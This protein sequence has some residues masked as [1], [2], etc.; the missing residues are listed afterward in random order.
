MIL[1]LL[2]CNGILSSSDIFYLHCYFFSI[3]IIARTLYNSL[4]FY[5]VMQKSVMSIPCPGNVQ[6]LLK[7]QLHC[8]YGIQRCR[9]TF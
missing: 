9:D 7:K 3:M 8:L 4:M 1:D 5:I 2:N 6:R